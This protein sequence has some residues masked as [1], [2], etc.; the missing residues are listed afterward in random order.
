MF[1]DSIRSLS[2]CLPGSDWY[3]HY[4]SALIVLTGRVS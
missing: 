3:V 2:Y 1:A 4:L